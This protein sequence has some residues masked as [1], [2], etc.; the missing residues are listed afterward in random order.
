M[1]IVEAVDA[2]TPSDLRQDFDESRQRQKELRQEADSIQ[3]EMSRTAP[4]QRLEDLK[5]RMYDLGGEINEADAKGQ[6]AD[7]RVCE[8]LRDQLRNGSLRAEAYDQDRSER[9]VVPVNDWEYLQLGFQGEL[10]KETG[11]AG[12]GGRHLIGVKIGKPAGD[13]P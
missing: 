11:A 3:D 8:Y 10:F 7:R 6:K 12:G 4:N 1:T 2:F 9:I 13:L 5:K